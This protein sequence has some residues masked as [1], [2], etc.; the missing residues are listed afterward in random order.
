MPSFSKILVIRISDFLRISTFDI[1]IYVLLF[2]SLL[3][4]NPLYA[5]EASREIAVT[6]AVSS[7]FKKDP[8]WRNDIAARLRVT[9]E[10][11]EKKFG[12]HFTLRKVLDW[13]PQDETRAMSLLIEEL[14]AS[15]PL[16]TDEVVIGFHH[17][18]KPLGKETVEDLDTVGTAEFFKGYMMIRDPFH[19]M[20]E[21]KRGSVLMHETAHL[22]GAVHNS[23]PDAL[24]SP[25]LSKNTAPAL[26]PENEEIIRL[27]K[28]VDFTR[29][30]DSFSPETL[31]SLIRIYEKLIRANPHGDFYYQLGLFYK[32]MGNQA[33]AVSVWEEAVKHDYANPYIHWQLGVFY[34]ENA[35]FDSAIRELGTAYAHFILPSQ[36]RE[37]LMAFNFLGVA[38]FQKGNIELAIFNW[39]KGLSVDPDNPEL[40]S[41]LAVAYLE[42][43]DTERA[44]SEFSKL[45]A[46]KPG[47]S[48]TLSSLGAAHLRRQDAAKAA[49]Y[50]E[51]ALAAKDR[52]AQT[53]Q[54][55]MMFQIPEDSM[56]LNLGAAYLSL[57]RPAEALEQLQKAKGLNA[58]AYEVYPNLAKT[59]LELKKPAEAV[60]ELNAGLQIR[61]DDPYAYAMLAQAYSET[62]NNAGALTAA[63]QALQYG[64]E[65]DFKANMHKNIAVLHLK[66][67]RQEEALAEL[68]NA[69]N[70]NWKDAQAH[71]QLGFIYA[72]TGR[73]AEAE[74]SLQNAL[75]IDPNQP[76]VKKALEQI[77]QK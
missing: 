58:K 54:S 76:D 16:G 21:T 41:N 51:Q 20:D 55:G 56:R 40:Q 26:D 23:N 14:R 73:F 77:K 5:Q 19:P 75:R 44:I 69:L 43:G 42:K 37:R 45:L 24:M 49:D 6:A 1:R 32:K 2:F 64:K 30:L 39:L 15:I 72:N 65:N 22:F 36:K 3:F 62:G 28:N 11:F 46:K 8:E 60:N 35:R 33:R 17:M 74:R 29:G 59:Y 38:Y 48:A 9:N 27:T 71:A 47:D 31:S 7:Q 52:P 57:H 66:G 18:T 13:V 68:K 67:N 10:M 63:R 61:K 50:L 34:Y 70:L 12:I 25:S 4:A 53:P